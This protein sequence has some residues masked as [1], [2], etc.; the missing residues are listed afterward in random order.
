MLW[1]STQ[2]AVPSLYPNG[3]LMNVS[4]SSLTL[5][6]DQDYFLVVRASDPNSDVDWHQALS[7]PTGLTYQYSQNGSTWS[8]Q[9][10]STGGNLASFNVEGN[11]PVPVPCAALL[12][13]SGLLGIAGFRKRIK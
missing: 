10:W 4:V 6:K 7:G 13:G 9:P 3:T 2:Y 12:F 8:W 1:A 11:T 5:T